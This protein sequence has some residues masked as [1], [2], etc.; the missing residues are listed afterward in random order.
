VPALDQW[1]TCTNS[2]VNLAITTL[3]GA[4]VY[5][6]GGAILLPSGS[7]FAIGGTGQ[8]AIFS[9]GSNPTDPGSWVTGPAFPTDT[10]A[11]PNWPTLTALDAPCALLPSGKVVLLAGNAEPTAGD[12]F[13]SFPVFLEYDPTSSATTL[14]Q[15]DVQPSLPAGNQTWQSCFL[16]L[17]T[18]QLL[19]SAQTNTLFLYTPDP[20]AGVPDPSWLP[21]NISVPTPMVQGHSYTL[22][23]TQLNGLSQACSYGDDAGMATNYP[24]VR[25]INP[26][27]GAVVYLRSHAF[28]T[29]GVAT[30]ASVQSCTIDIP[31]NLATGN[32]DLQVVAN[33][34]A[35]AVQSVQIAAQ[36]CFFIVDNSTFSIG[37]IDSF[38]KASSPVNAVFNPAFYVVIEG[39]TPAEIGID[40]S[41]PIG[42]QLL[43]PPILPNVPSPFPGHVQITFVGPMIPEDPSLPPTPQRFTFPFEMTFLDDS[44]FGTATTMVTLNAN[45]TAPSASVDASAEI[46]LTA[47]PN[48]YI[49]HGDQTLNPPEPWYLSQDIRVFQVAA[50]SSGVF[51]ATLASSGTPSAIGTAFI[52]AA[53]TNL[54]NNVGT[55][56]ADFDAMPQDEDAEVLQLL[57]N[58]PN[59]GSAV[60]NFA[61]ARVRLRDTSDAINVRV[62]FRIWQAQQTNATYDG[63]TYSRATNGE[64]QPIPVL[65][66]LG[67][68]IITIPFFATPRVATSA[69]LHTQTD[70]FNRHDIDA[71]T[72]ETDYFFGCWL[73]INQPNDLR[74]PQRIQGISADGPF[75]TTSPLFPIQRFMVAAHQCLIVEI[76]YDPD[77]ITGPVDPS[78]SDKLA[79]R[80]LA[81]VDAPNPGNPASRRVPQTFEIR[82]TG[83]KLPP[84]VRPDELM[85]EWTDIPDHSTAEI[86]LPT[87]SADAV[88][89]LAA[90]LYASHLL[91]RADANTLRFP[92]AGVT[93]LPIPTGQGISF[94]G[95]LTVDLPAGITD[96]DVHSAVI[97]QFTS[98]PAFIDENLTNAIAAE[99]TKQNRQWRRTTGTFKLTI[100][101]STKALLLAP[102]ERYYS[103][104]KWVAEAIP[105]T[106]RWYKV[107]QR[108]L[109]QLAGRVTFMGGNPSQI[110]ATGTGIWQLP[111]PLK[112]LEEHFTGK[113]ETLIYDRF[114]DFEAFTLETMSGALHRFDSREPHVGELARRAWEARSRIRVVVDLSHAR[115]PASIV[116]LL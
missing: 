62:F 95:L 81:F 107:M 83:P 39:Y 52:Q 68:E 23:G 5:E 17:P 96:G 47:N 25:L 97:R 91:S 90:T 45:F 51:G 66:V 7:V 89:A 115:H 98:V 78:D 73:D 80:N 38:V 88:L 50:G 4:I 101:I 33:G 70:D 103:V 76:A 79:Q 104:M 102:E 65:G 16:I 63:T 56:R 87:V 41:K 19:C 112:H 61:V 106:G 99:D 109:A 18:G 43:N 113:V 58:D 44:M 36:D 22:N 26:T 31:D 67:D 93:Y 86:Y 48:P 92:A 27:T 30:G 14:P 69:Q 46:T 28:S 59:T 37:E 34:I 13:S 108:Y 42:P 71:S 8:T 57:P 10:S 6:T 12:Y 3:S 94:P 29:M 21:A 9:P 85:I 60:Y 100:P 84:G 32:W 15:L 54:R 116:Y 74:Y 82:P 111:P 110:P 40:T 53:V 11:S 105:P 35:S 77:P 64:S 75:D 2:P 20:A 114:G 72:G 49:L 1:V 55:T 24:L